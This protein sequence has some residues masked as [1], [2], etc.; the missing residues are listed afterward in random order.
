MKKRVTGMGQDLIYSP[1][2]HYVSAQKKSHATCRVI[3]SVEICS[4]EMLM[5]T[6]SD[7]DSNPSSG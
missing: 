7:F 4:A 3:G 1:S 6:C 2:R 5:V